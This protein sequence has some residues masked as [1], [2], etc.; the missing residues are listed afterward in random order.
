MDRSR[1]SFSPTA[2]R[3]LSR[4]RALELV[5]SVPALLISTGVLTACGGPTVAPAAGTALSSPPARSPSPGDRN[6]G[7]STALTPAAAADGPRRGGT[8]IVAYQGSAEHLDPA[9]Y[10]TIEDENA[11]FA[12]YNGLTRLD[13][14]LQVHPDLAVSWTASEDLKTWTF[15]LRQGVS[16]HH[17]KVFNADDVVYTFRRILDPTVASPGRSIFTFLDSVEKRD[18]ATVVFHLS[19]PYVDLPV[20]V[21]SIYA[22]IVP[23]DRSDEQILQQPSGTGPFRFRENVIGD[24]LTLV[25]NDQYW[26]KGLP[27]L[28]A[29]RQVTLP[30]EA[31]MT[32]ALQGGQIDIIWQASA[33]QVQAL[34][35]VPGVVVK[36]V[37]SGGYVPLVMRA[38][39][40]PFNDVRVRQAMKYVVDR[41]QM[42]K[43]AM[44]G[45]G[46]LANDQPIPPVQPLYTDIGLRGRDI[47]RAKQLLRDAGYPDGLD[48]T[49]YTSPGRPGMVEQ[50]VAFQEMARP[51]GI[52]V[53]IQQVPIDAYWANYW[54]K[55]DLCFSNWFARPTVDEILA[56]TYKSDAK[57]NESFWKNSSLD[58]IILAAREERDSAKRRDLYARAERIISEDGASIIAFFKPVLYAFRT[59][60]QG[61]A[62]S[63][64]SIFIPRTIWLS[65]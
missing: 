57:W 5:S 27:Y 33:Q 10:V 65:A 17:G 30:E 53:R 12:I 37:P 9:R 31:S 16:F 8:L 23:S 60:V 3:P 43:V 24:H 1:A 2:L 62:A 6:A 52:R 41:D 4:R 32:A 51:A 58:Q 29:I 40:P 44:L 25:R 61:F 48:L 36:V 55:K 46:D 56:T 42:R 38:D 15:H 14:T 7:S 45:L 47:D 26:E 20:V 18:D 13:E 63:P 21:A 50:A 34:R 39:R 35:G 11:A 28:D 49:L 59:R 22:R 64:L 54:M 19:S